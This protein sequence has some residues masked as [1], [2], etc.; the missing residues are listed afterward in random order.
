MK[1]ATI[2]IL[3]A[4]AIVVYGAKPILKKVNG[5]KPTEKEIGILKSVG[6][7]IALL[8]AMLIFTTK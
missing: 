7:I 1:F 6:L 2:L 8:G 3:I 5:R 4:G